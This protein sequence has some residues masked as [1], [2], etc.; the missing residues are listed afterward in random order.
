[1]NGSLIESKVISKG[2]IYT[3][4]NHAA[5]GKHWFTG[6]SSTRFNGEID[7]VRIYNRVLTDSEI[8]MLYHEGGW[9]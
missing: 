5:I 7:N 9:K 4:V 3:I 1:M 2:P 8:Q 6:A